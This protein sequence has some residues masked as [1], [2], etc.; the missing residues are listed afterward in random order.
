M[1]QPYCPGITVCAR[2]PRRQIRSC[3]A[4][5]ALTRSEDLATVYASTAGACGAVPWP[6]GRYK[7]VNAR[8]AALNPARVTSR[9]SHT[10][11]DATDAYAQSVF[12]AK[13]LGYAENPDDPDLPGHAECP[14]SRRTKARSWPIRKAT[15]SA[16]SR[17]NGRPSRR[18]G[19][20]SR[21]RS[22]LPQVGC[23][24]EPARGREGHWRPGLRF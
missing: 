23:G 7:P 6:S 15:S 10:S 5:H 9:I 3:A 14:I 2:R 17:T 11:I 12:W 18:S 1:R 22:Q 8:A 20:G 24:A 13:V 21:R 4:S 19:S 16:S